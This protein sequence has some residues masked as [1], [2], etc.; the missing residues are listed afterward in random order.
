MAAALVIWADE[1]R[2]RPAI[3]VVG[4]MSLV[5]G[6]ILH[7]VVGES[8]AL[9]A[10]SLRS[11]IRCRGNFGRRKQKIV[12]EGQG[13]G[14]RKKIILVANPHTDCGGVIFCACGWN[15]KVFVSE[16]NCKRRAKLTVVCR[17]IE[18]L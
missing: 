16:D 2:Q 13:Q 17:S 11:L 15:N 9:P 10:P 6:C 12:S 3:C 18:F 4:Y 7:V 5:I 14:R 8:P 1:S